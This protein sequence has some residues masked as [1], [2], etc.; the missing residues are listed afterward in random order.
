MELYAVIKDAISMAQKADNIDLMKKLYDVQAELLDLQNRNLEL[1]QENMA[2]KVAAK[3][4]EHIEYNPAR[5]LIYQIDAGNKIGP[6]CTKCFEKE[7]KLFS[8]RRW[9]DGR[10]HC[11]NCQETVYSNGM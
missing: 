9:D 5:T 7:G 3:I 11:P 10:W 8:M 2:L 6:Y 4:K 1:E